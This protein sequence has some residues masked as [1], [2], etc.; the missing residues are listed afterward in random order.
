VKRARRIEVLTFFIQV[1]IKS[2]EL[3]IAIRRHQIV[4]KGAP[5]R[6]MVL[7]ILHRELRLDRLPGDFFALNCLYVTSFDEA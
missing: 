4:T 1:N 3:A 7:K 2:E 6:Q 5:P